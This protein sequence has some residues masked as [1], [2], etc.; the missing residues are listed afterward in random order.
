MNVD[1]KENGKSLVYKS[2]V[3]PIEVY[4]NDGKYFFYKIEK[5]YDERTATMKENMSL[6]SISTVENIILF[7]IKEQEIKYRE[8]ARRNMTNEFYQK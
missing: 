4:F 2:P 6:K 5:K 7:M 8:I 3:A 1:H